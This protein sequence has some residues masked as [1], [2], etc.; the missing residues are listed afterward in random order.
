MYATREGGEDTDKTM[1]EKL[2]RKMVACP[3]CGGSVVVQT[4]IALAVE[5][6]TPDD[7]FASAPATDDLAPSQVQELVEAKRTGRYM[8]FANTLNRGTTA[9]ANPAKLDRAYL[10]F[11]T[12]ADR[13]ELDPAVIACLRSEYDVPGSDVYALVDNT[14]T[15]AMVDGR[16]IAFFPSQTVIGSGK[17]AKVK[18]GPVLDAVRHWIRTRFGYV[19]AGASAFGSELRQK[20]VG[21]FARLSVGGKS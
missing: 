16:L 15:A 12:R 18:T 3:H 11:W 13:R 20:S 9:T 5:L 21:Q 4:N 8:A 19:P 17:N 6:Q 14:V 2:N 7:A 10:R 1:D